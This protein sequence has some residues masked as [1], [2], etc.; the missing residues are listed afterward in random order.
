[1]VRRPAKPFGYVTMVVFGIVV[2]VLMLL[3][4]RLGGLAG[5]ACGGAR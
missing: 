4:D 3:A 1:V 2:A 5:A